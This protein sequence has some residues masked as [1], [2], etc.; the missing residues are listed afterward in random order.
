MVRKKSRLDIDEKEA[1]TVRLIYE[2]YASGKG[3]KAIVGYL[4]KNG[5]QT[6]L[7]NSFSVAQLRTILMNPVYVGKVRFNV[8]RDW[9][10]K[11]R[12]NINPNPIVVDGIHVAIIS[13]ELWEKV[14]FMISQKA[15]KPTRIYDGEY[16]LTGILKCPVCGAGMVISRVTAKRKDGS[17]RRLIYYACGNWKNKGT[18]VCRSNMV[19]VETSNE[20]VYQQ[21]NKILSNDKFFQEVMYRV[22]REH[23]IT[24]ENAN[25]DRGVQYIC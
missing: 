12:H 15:G 19:R 25:K 22:N 16:P 13:D 21:L 24:Q 4:N 2:L 8:R 6:K 17:K 5:Y 1:I 9:N 20:F 3:Y 18:A 23:N 11:R 7:N 10:E 14:Q